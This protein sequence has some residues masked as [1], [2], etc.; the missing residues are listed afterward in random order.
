MKQFSDRLETIQE[1][2][3]KI[4]FIAEELAD[5]PFGSIDQ[6]S[7]KRMHS[8]A[9]TAAAA[10]VTCEIGLNYD[11]AKFYF[12]RHRT[13]FYHYNKKHLSYME[14]PKIYPEYYEFYTKLRDLYL[15]NDENIFKSKRTYDFFKEIE[16]ARQQQNAI[17]RRLK[18]L[19][20]EAKMLGL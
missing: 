9:R 1:E 11:Q 4:K 17:E 20:E 16:K 2:I 10:F 6:N 19:N 7:R 3:K 15:N 12:K 13:S 8:L 18:K 5:I 14:N